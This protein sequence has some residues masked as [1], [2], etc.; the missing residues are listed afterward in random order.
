MKEKIRIA[1]PGEDKILTD[2]AFGAKRTW[3][4]PESF[5][6]RW[7]DELTI[8]KDYIRNNIV[9]VAERNRRIVGFY[10]IV[11]VSNDFYS[12]NVLVKKG[13]W[14]EHLFVKPAFQK[15]GIGS[16]LLKHALNYCVENWIDELNI[17]VDPHA[18]G[19]YEKM[20]ATYI[21]NSPSSIDDREVPVYRFYLEI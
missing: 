4:Y 2:I 6:E 21:E 12:G 17:F 1:L 9:F 11:T 5:Y 16:N 8:S 7:V 13:F 10:S 14:M 18:T 20:G 19:F 15:K 3:I